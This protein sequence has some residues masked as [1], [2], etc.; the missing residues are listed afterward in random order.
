MID[1]PLSF[2]TSLELQL[3]RAIAIVALLGLMFA[4]SNP[5]K[6]KSQKIPRKR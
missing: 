1:L 6:I 5:V 4:L 2:L 3:Y